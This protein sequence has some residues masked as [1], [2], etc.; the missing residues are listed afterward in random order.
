M[1]ISY[2]GTRK[3]IEIS[4]AEL[5]RK[6]D[7]RDAMR[8]VGEALLPAGPAIKWWRFEPEADPLNQDRT[9]STAGNMNE[10]GLRAIHLQLWDH[11]RRA[12]REWVAWT[13][14]KTEAEKLRDTFK[15]Y[16]SREHG[17]LNQHLMDVE[18]LWP[19]EIDMAYQGG[20]LHT[21]GDRLDKGKAHDLELVGLQIVAVRT[22]GESGHGYTFFYPHH[23]TPG[24]M[25][26]IMDH[27]FKNAMREVEWHAIGAQAFAKLTHYVD[28]EVTSQLLETL[29][30]R[31]GLAKA[32]PAR[33][34]PLL[35]LIA[36]LRER[37]STPSATSLT[38]REWRGL[39]ERVIGEAKA[40]RL[41]DRF[42]MIHSGN[43]EGTD[44]KKLKEC[45][46]FALKCLDKITLYINKHEK[47]PNLLRRDQGLIQAVLSEALSNAV[48]FHD[49]NSK[50][51]EIQVRI[52]NKN[53]A[54]GGAI[55]IV[56]KIAPRLAV[57]PEAYKRLWDAME[58][59]TTGS[60]FDPLA[61]LEHGGVGQVI[62]GLVHKSL[63]SYKFWLGPHTTQKNFYK[64]RME[65]PGG[66][67]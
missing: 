27:P 59:D 36:V 35:R 23:Q 19:F 16:A 60:N 8:S 15:E 1:K 56:S 62:Y 24:A 61:R 30:I 63:D 64:F 32:S 21:V 18:H 6:K 43:Q 40:F 29:S 2:I 26:L 67:S 12:D 3:W 28:V 13:R 45:Q 10:P 39:F 50:S 58:D 9:P 55:E 41:G 31:P 20:K 4:D 14:S 65:W 34:L 5:L 46:G 51:D 17:S 22:E 48:R 49:H 33:V 44:D 7:V 53:D 37:E 25:V 11:G 54:H 66:V 47:F 52:E 42:E 38:A 57:W